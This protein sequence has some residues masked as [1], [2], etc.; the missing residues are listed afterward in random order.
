MRYVRR[1]LA[2]TEPG[3][4]DGVAHEHGDGHG[5][6]AARDRSDSASGVD[7]VGMNVADENGAF[8]L[9]FLEAL[10][11]IFQ[12]VGGFG[13]VRYFIGAD[14]DYSGAGLDPVGGDVAGFAHG[15]D[16]DVGAANYVGE[17]AGL[18]MA[19]GYGGV[20]VQEQKGHGLADDVAAAEDYGVGT[21]DCYVVAA[22]NFHAAGGS[23]GDQAGTATNQSPKIDG[24]KAVDIFG[25]IDGFE[26][27]FGVHLFGQR[28]LDED[29]VD[30]IV[31]VEF[32][33]RWRSSS[34]VTLAEG[35]CIQLARPR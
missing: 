27:A 34:V 28:E 29:A 14:I 31:G 7:G 9:K 20:G 1:S 19:D 10:R 25:G 32:A 15:G 8:F 22:K 6:D 35:V 13:G 30:A 16:E 11:E 33:T 23:A 5:A 21:F 18:G 2:A 4:F 24:M 26:D 3:G 17:I 12:Q